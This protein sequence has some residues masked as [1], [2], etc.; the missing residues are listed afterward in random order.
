MR[1]GSATP[2]TYGTSPTQRSAGRSTG[3]RCT[4]WWTDDDV[5]RLIG[6]VEE[7]ARE[8]RA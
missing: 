8:R 3:H 1:Y 6:A 5:E 4:S 2:S 7:V